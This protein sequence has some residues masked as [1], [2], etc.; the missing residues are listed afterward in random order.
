MTM[1]FCKKEYISPEVYELIKIIGQS[2]LRQLLAETRTSLWF[3]ILDDEA[4]D[5]SHHEQLSLSIHW[6]NNCFTK[7]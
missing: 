6:V 7:S 4:R 3:S 1:C 2:A 5:T